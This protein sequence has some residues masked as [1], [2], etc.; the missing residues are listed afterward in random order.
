MSEWI[1]KVPGE[2]SVDAVGLWQIISFGRDGFSL[3]GNELVD[4]VRRNLAALFAKGARPVIG[5]T[6]NIH[7]WMPVNYGGS[8]EEMIDNIIN[9]WIRCGRDPDWGDV[10]FALPHIYEQ[11]RTD[12]AQP[13]TKVHL[14]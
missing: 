3:S 7:I 12:D 11:K 8:A 2:L 14:S 9:E 1:E 5:A 4:Y 13:K 6:D 10:W